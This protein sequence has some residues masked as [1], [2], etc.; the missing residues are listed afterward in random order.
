MSTSFSLSYWQWWHLLESFCRWIR[1]KETKFICSVP[2]LVTELSKQKTFLMGKQITQVDN[3]GWFP[4]MHLLLT[5]PR[6]TFDA[7]VSGRA[8]H[9]LQKNIHHKSHS[10]Q[11]GASFIACSIDPTKAGRGREDQAA[12]QT[13]TAR[14]AFSEVL[15]LCTKI[16]KEKDPCLKESICYTEMY[17]KWEKF[18]VVCSAI[19]FFPRNWGSPKNRKAGNR[20]SQEAGMGRMEYKQSYLFFKQ[21]WHCK[22]QFGR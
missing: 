20:C 4:L 2:L 14:E 12:P 9:L 10:Q 8:Q 15:T 17:K 22:Y 7:L 16:S 21:I 3:G 18:S 13:C 1:K 6:P 5:Q 11:M 19:F